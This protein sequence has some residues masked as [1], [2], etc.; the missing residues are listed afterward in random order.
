MV[1]II[2]AKNSEW[3]RCETGCNW[4]FQSRTISCVPIATNSIR[5][6]VLATK[7]SQF[8]YWPL[9]FAIPIPITIVRSSKKKRKKIQVSTQ[10]SIWMMNAFP[11]SEEIPEDGSLVPVQ[12]SGTL[13]CVSCPANSSHQIG[14]TNKIDWRLPL[15]ISTTSTTGSINID[16]SCGC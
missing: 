5:P 10:C 1:K 9:S 2:N 12:L 6:F 15:G 8:L 11:N 4:S 13:N 16:W 3:I 14:W 7:T